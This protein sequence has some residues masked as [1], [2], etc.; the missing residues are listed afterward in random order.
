MSGDSV[1]HRLKDLAKRSGVEDFTPH[2]LRRFAASNMRKSGA[3]ILD[4]A[5][6]LRHEDPVTTIRCYLRDDPEI[7]AITL[8]KASKG[9]FG[10]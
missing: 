1:Y 10:S 5:C 3:S 4:I 6:A 7:K 8:A 9:L 2:S